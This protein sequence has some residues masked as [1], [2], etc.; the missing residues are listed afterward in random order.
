MGAR[1]RGQ[2][3]TAF[4]VAFGAESFFLGTTL[5]KE[6]IAALGVITAVRLAVGPGPCS[7]RFW[8]GAVVAAATAVAHT[9]GLMA[10]LLLLVVGLR[11]GVRRAATFL[12]GCAPLAL[13]LGAY[14]TWLSGRPWQS[15]YFFLT[16]TS[17]PRLVW[18]KGRIL[19]DLLV[20]TEGGLIL[21]SPFLLFAFVGLASAWRTGRRAE[22]AVT[23]MFLCGLWLAA[24]SWLSQFADEASFSFG[25]GPRML[26]PAVP[27]LA[28]FAG[29]VLE[30]ANRGP[31]LLAAIPSVF[32]GYLSAQAGFIPTQSTSNS[33]SYAVKTWLSGTGMGVLFKEALPLWL[34]LDTLHTV[35]G[36][37]EVRVAGILRL[38]HRP[39]GLAVLRNQFL[40]LGLN[41]L[42]LGGV[43]WIINR[44]WRYAGL[45]QKPASGKA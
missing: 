14:N 30:R 19:L 35:V 1:R 34:G 8:A 42:T 37:R 13:A 7:R 28:S 6:N 45:G 26:F 12:L 18:P 25:L 43:A 16:A 44:V 33:L 2:L 41:L 38:L 4:L 17:A 31:L 39:E 22:T 3:L 23:V 9:T 36:R 29:P 40:F 21:Y 24:S 10:F 15:E 11:E 32:C 5:F 27:L 20:G